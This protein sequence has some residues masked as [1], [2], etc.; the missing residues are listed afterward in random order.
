MTGQDNDDAQGP[1]RRELSAEAKENLMRIATNLAIA[2]ARRDHAR[3]MA[4]R[5]KASAGPGADLPQGDVG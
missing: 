2:D 4:A 1:P 3:D 5:A